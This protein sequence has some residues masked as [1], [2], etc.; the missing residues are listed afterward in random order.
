MATLDQVFIT[1]SFT[2]IIPNV[3]ICA[4]HRLVLNG[5]F[6]SRSYERFH[7]LSR[8]T[9]EISSNKLIM[10]KFV[11]RTIPMFNNKAFLAATEKLY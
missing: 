1:Q 6:R 8:K 9:H 10:T 3:S 7:F 11:T 5:I 4:H 2:I